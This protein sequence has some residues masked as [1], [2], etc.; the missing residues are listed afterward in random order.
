MQFLVKTTPG[1]QRLQDIP[2][3]FCI[4]SCHGMTAELFYIV[5]F[6]PITLYTAKQ[7][8]ELRQGRNLDHSAWR[9]ETQAKIYNLYL[10]Q[11]KWLSD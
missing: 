2:S 3:I 6:L 1:L 9:I 11:F 5:A 8:E 10:N 7:L 4:F